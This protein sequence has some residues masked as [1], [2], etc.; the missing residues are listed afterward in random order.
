[1]AN[2]S[3]E[4]RTHDH[5]HQADRV[6][7]ANKEFFDVGMDLVL[8]AVVADW[9]VDNY[10]PYLKVWNGGGVW[11]A[12]MDKVPPRHFS[13][14]WY[15]GA[16][17]REAVLAVQEAFPKWAIQGLA[18]HRQEVAPLIA[19]INQAARLI[20]R[21]PGDPEWE[22]PLEQVRQ[23]A[24]AYPR[25]WVLKATLHLFSSTNG[26]TRVL[27]SFSLNLGVN[28]LYLDINSNGSRSLED[29]K[30]TEDRMAS[31][32]RTAKKIEKLFPRTA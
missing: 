27:A 28:G 23:Y 1:M 16:T 30:A 25:G 21:V 11:C 22:Q 9:G 14:P 2:H 18:T 13:K 19:R 8:A 6:N 12:T 17:A 24:T 20:E 4:I 15:E 29:L 31:I 26:G 10:C 32:R 7:S 3:I 5:L